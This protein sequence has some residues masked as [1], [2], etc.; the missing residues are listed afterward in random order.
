M[1]RA[2]QGW[3]AYQE[4]AQI[5]RQTQEQ[6]HAMHALQ[7]AGQRALLKQDSKHRR[8]RQAIQAQ[9]QPQNLT[10]KHAQQRLTAK[11]TIAT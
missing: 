10:A 1:R 5:S 11:A 3:H 2:L 8:R 7:V 9:Q 4:D 6:A